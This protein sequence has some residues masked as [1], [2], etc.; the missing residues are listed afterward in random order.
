MYKMSAGCLFPLFTDHI[1]KKMLEKLNIC[2]RTHAAFYD[3]HLYV[4]IMVTIRYSAAHI[5][6]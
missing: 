4:K 1:V 6:T 3:E 5:T 2:V